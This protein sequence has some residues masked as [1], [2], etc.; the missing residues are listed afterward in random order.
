MTHKRNLKK[1]TNRWRKQKNR[2]TGIFYFFYK[3]CVTL[4]IYL[5]LYNANW[6]MKFK[7]QKVQDLISTVALELHKKSKLIN[8]DKFCKMTARLPYF[9][10]QN[11]TLDVFHLSFILYLEFWCTF[12]YTLKNSN[13]EFQKFPVSKEI[14]INRNSLHVFK[15]TKET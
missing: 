4:Q 12:F 13:P 5:E 1:S 9:L 10:C 11:Y 3:L 7:P 6:I 14:A 15:K 8:C 2:T